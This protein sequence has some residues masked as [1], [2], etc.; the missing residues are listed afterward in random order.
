MKD[1]SK[2]LTL[3]TEE[4]FRPKDNKQER[5]SEAEVKLEKVLTGVSYIGNDCFYYLAA[6]ACVLHGDAIGCRDCD[7][8]KSI[9]DDEDDDED[10]E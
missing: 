9:N 4:D 3:F 6:G 7:N 1:Q 5:L 2:Q 8:Y 10:N